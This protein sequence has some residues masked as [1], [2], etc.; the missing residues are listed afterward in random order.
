MARLC[1]G[2]LLSLDQISDPRERKWA[3]RKPCPT[4]IKMK[5]AAFQILFGEGPWNCR[6]GR[7]EKTMSVPGAA[8]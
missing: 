6:G 3:G 5:R 4:S 8:P 7:G 2:A 1:P